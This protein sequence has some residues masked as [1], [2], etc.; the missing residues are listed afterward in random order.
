MFL[1]TASAICGCA[2]A[3]PERLTGCAGVEG[4][5]ERPTGGAGA[6][7]WPER[8]GVCW[9]DDCAASTAHNANAATATVNNFI[10]V[11]L[12]VLR[13]EYSSRCAACAPARWC[14]ARVRRIGVHD[15]V[16]ATCRKSVNE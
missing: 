4:W 8:P 11:P 2:P 7:G 10:G 15:A 1:N 9:L 5:P 3:W 16:Q 14:H 12:R 13:A 6:E